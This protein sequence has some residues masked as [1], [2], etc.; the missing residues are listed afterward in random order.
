VKNGP[1]SND[2]RERTV[3]TDELWEKGAKNDEKQ[4]DPTLTSISKGW[5]K[6]KKKVKERR[7]QLPKKKELKKSIHLGED[8]FG[9]EQEGTSSQGR[10]G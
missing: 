8:T 6:R 4:A 2:Q 5:K 3:R 9:G 7:V 10:G 1:I